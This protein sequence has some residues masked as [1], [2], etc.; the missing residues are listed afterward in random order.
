MK[1]TRRSFVVAACLLACTAMALG[2][3]TGSFSRTLQI[4]GT[5]DVEVSTGS[6]NITVHA[7]SSNSISINA[8]IKANDQW[9]G[10]GN[11]SAEEKIKRIESNPPISQ[12]GNLV[13]IGRINDSDLRRNVSISYDVTLPASSHLRTESG[14]GDVNVDGVTGPARLQTGSGNVTAKNLGEDVRIATGSGDVHIDRSKG[15]V[16]V[17]T[18]SGTVE[19]SGIGG[20]FYAETGSG[21]ITL[22]QEASG[23]VVAH[24]GSGNVRL[25]DLNGGLDA[26]SG[27]GD[28]EADG[29]ARN[30]WT[31]HT[32]SG[33]IDL[34]LPSKAAFTLDARSSSGEVTVNHPITLQGAIKRNQV[35]GKVGQGGPLLHLQTSSGEIRVN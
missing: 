19:A 23:T 4:S 22:H 25:H 32:G 11:L 10:G 24:T 8:R 1:K 29:D 16:R 7:G 20:A 18:G 6:G 13:T 15:P 14:S 30:D 28:I 12:S 21:D 17:N 34:K 9:F 26:H 35:Q 31:V 33:N 5:P 3:A 27:S 2:E